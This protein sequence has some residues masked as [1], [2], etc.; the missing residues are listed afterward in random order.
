[1][2]GAILPILLA[3]WRRGA[4]IQR[5]SWHM[6]VSKPYPILY[7]LFQQKEIVQSQ[8]PSLFPRNRLLFPLSSVQTALIISFCTVVLYG[9]GTWSLTLREERRLRVFENKV[10]G[11]YLGLSR[12][13]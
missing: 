12:S 8:T 6:P 3:P 13:K 2:R 1:M 10:W 7:R 4:D 11:E 5:Q 9:C